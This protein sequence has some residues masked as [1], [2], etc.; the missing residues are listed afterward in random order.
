MASQPKNIIIVCPPPEWTYNA[1]TH[2]QVGGS[3]AG[4]MSGLVLKRSG[5]HV[6][7]FERSPSTLLQSQGAGITFGIEGQEFL[8]KHVLVNREFFVNIYLRQTLGRDGVPVDQEK[9][10][11]KMTSWDLLYFVLRACFDGMESVYCAVPERKEGEGEAGYEYDRKVVGVKEEGVG[12]KVEFED[13]EGKK[14]S[15]MADMVIAADGPSSTIRRLLMPDVERRYV[16]YVAFRGTVP[17]SEASKLLKDTFTHNFTFYHGPG[18]QI[19]S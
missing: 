2:H 11:Q 6:R 15:A 7:I 4:L 8:S 14:D 12:V 9:R 19:L 17:E 10:Q 5:H 3:L 13:A 18:I 16:G 1:L